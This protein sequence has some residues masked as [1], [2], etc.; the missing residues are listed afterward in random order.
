[1]TNYLN[2]VKIALEDQSNKNENYENAFNEMQTANTDQANKNENYENT[3]NDF[4]ARIE[5]LEEMLTTLAESV[6]LLDYRLS[7]IDDPENYP[8]E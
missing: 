8:A 2:E 4:K 1:M 6:Q 5:A 3:F 7:A